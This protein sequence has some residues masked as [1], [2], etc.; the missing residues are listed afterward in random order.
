[1]VLQIEFF[2][3]CKNLPGWSGRI[4]LTSAVLPLI[5]NEDVENVEEQ[6][7]WQSRQVGR[8]N[9]APGLFL[10]LEFSFCNKHQGASSSHFTMGELI[11]QKWRNFSMNHHH[12]HLC[13]ILFLISQK[14]YFFF[15]LL[16]QKNDHSGTQM[17]ADSIY[18]F[19]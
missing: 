6:V 17:S 18:L 5:M 8:N 16:F 1:M 7:D 15:P 3:H 14:Q 2:F 19:W 4:Q 13:T 12:D 11:L 10:W 9:L